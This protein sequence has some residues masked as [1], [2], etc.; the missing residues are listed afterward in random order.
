[1]TV[2]YNHNRTFRVWELNG[3]WYG[4]ETKYIAYGKLTIPYKDCLHAGSR[5]EI[6]DLIET[7]CRFD[8]L[9]NNGMGGAEAA[10]FALF[11]E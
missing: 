7:H 4:V 11:K 6:I 8:E 3:I 9:V 5:D 2:R 10:K 1:M